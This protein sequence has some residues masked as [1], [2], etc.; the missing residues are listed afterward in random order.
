MLCEQR[1]VWEM[2]RARAKACHLY[3][4]WKAIVADL[5]EHFRE[6]F[7]IWCSCGREPEASGGAS[8]AHR[9]S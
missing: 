8:Q 4:E 9:V 2:Y 3:P 6:Q 5:Q 1:K 7:N